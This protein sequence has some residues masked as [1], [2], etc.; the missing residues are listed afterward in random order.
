MPRRSTVICWF[1]RGEAARRRVSRSA[2]ILMGKDSAAR[3][4]RVTTETG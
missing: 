4:K 3:V 1:T 2:A